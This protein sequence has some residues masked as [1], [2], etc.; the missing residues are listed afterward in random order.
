MV[1][2]FKAFA[3]YAVF[4]LFFFY[5]ARLLFILT[6]YTEASGYK[7]ITLAATFTHGIRLDISATG[8]LFLIPVLLSIPALFISG[9]WF[10]IF[11][12]FY[13]YLFIVIASAIVVGDA[14]LY[15][16]WGFRMDN[17]PLMYLKT[18]GEAAAS[19]TTSE[20]IIVPLAI[21]FLSALFIYLY[22]KYFDRFL[23]G[24]NRVRYP[25]VAAL[26]SMVIWAS[27][28]LPIRGGT[29]VA[30]INA[31]SVYFNE[32]AFIN[33]SAINVFWNVGHSLFVSEPSR[34]PYSYSDTESAVASF[35]SLM[36]N[37]GQTLKVLNNNNPN[38]LMIVLEGFGSTLIGPLG[39]D[40][41]ATPCFNSYVDE[42][43]LF[44]NFFASGTRTDKA[45]P[46]ILSGY[47]AQPL[48]SIMKKPEKTQTL[49]GIVRSLNGSGYQSSFWYGGDIN[50]AN[51]NSFVINSGFRSIV[52]KKNFDPT[53]YNSKWGVHDHVLLE[54]LA[55]SMMTQAE[56][57]V[58]V[59]LTLSSH[60]PF[61][62]PTEPYFTG[63]DES[64]RFRNSVY[65]AD[66][67]LGDFI[68]AS[69]K[70]GWWE[71]TLVILVADHCRRS[72]EPAHS[73]SLFRIPMLWIGGAVEEK[74]MKIDKFGCQND[75]PVT[76]LNQLGKK[77]EFPFGKDLLSDRS[78][79]F[80]FYTFNEGFGFITDT[81]AYIY[82]H[83]L[84]APVVEE[85]IGSTAAGAYG[86]AFLQVLYDDY[87][88]R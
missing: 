14:A 68:E 37:N 60:E 87:L 4:W 42:G 49:P 19:A 59:I 30:P 36:R 40:S 29:D 62:I 80:S 46:A 55:D 64:T 18:P 24:L 48:T 71:N 21:A 25:V 16:Y 10:R 78:N 1:K 85:G 31:G 39:G 5:C 12:S 86:K 61:E 8:Y 79:S 9:Q 44:T 88:K 74:G 15:K 43:I 28:I 11:V 75:I 81:S 63:D 22:N 84:G 20:L 70:C 23:D 27:L 76:L 34:N 41:L 67:S 17:T 53:F 77:S 50:F 73:E 72:D 82:D 66:K 2:R 35:D 54:A 7:I 45:M 47:P 38:V 3:A 83:K 56:P 32:N 51:F 6:H 26:I 52:T 33:H 13:S 69:R 65:Y 58:K 57:F